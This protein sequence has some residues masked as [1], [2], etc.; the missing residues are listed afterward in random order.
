MPEHEHD[1]ATDATG[2]GTAIADSVVASPAPEET[3]SHPRESGEEAEDGGEESKGYFGGLGP[4]EAARRRWAGRDDPSRSSDPRIGLAAGL[5]KKA[6]K[7]DLQ[8]YRAWK[9]L[10][11]ELEG[12][13]LARD[14]ADGA[15][16]WEL[17]TPEQRR[18]LLALLEGRQVEER[19]DGT[20]VIAP[21]AEE[22]EESPPGADA[23]PPSP[24]SG[25]PSA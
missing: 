12:E 25:F 14:G 19:E 17:I 9:E 18:A 13:R 21:R 1:D 20:I 6:E 23:T 16:A 22:G 11:D 5:F 10:T 4:A 3:V 2:H 24:A 15:R 7:G 8:A